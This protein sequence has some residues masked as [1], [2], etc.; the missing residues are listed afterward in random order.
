VDDE[1]ATD[2]DDSE[3]DESDDPNLSLEAKCKLLEKE[4]GEDLSD[5]E[6]ENQPKRAKL[7]KKGR[8]AEKKLTKSSKVTSSNGSSE[9]SLKIRE[10]LSGLKSI[11]KDFTEKETLQTN[12]SDNED[13]AS[14]H[15]ECEDEGDSDDSASNWKKNLAEKA[16]QS[17]YQRQVGIPSFLLRP[18]D[19]DTSFQVILKKSGH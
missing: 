16:S 10:T 6:E 14:N 13:D 2:S 15:S 12:A 5:S 7:S 19:S 9:L 1:E 3:E 8:V 11:S 17:F 18:L 4:M